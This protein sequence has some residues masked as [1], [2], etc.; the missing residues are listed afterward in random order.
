MRSGK[1]P[2]TRRPSLVFHQLHGTVPVEP[3]GQTRR[4]RRLRPPSRR[5][6]QGTLVDHLLPTRRFSPKAVRRVD[7]MTQTACRPCLP[8]RSHHPSRR[9][10]HWGADGLSG[11]PRWADRRAVGRIR[12]RLRL[13]VVP[14]RVLAGLAPAGRHPARHPLGCRL[15]LKRTLRLRTQTRQTLLYLRLARNRHHRFLGQSRKRLVR[16]RRRRLQGQARQDALGRRGRWRPLLNPDFLVSRQNPL[17]LRRRSNQTRQRRGRFRRDDLLGRRQ[18]LR[19]RRRG[20]R[21]G[22][23]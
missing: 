18:R 12:N 11:E 8:I 2:I 20:Y 9:P 21:L 14:F 19:A 16:S 17:C 4:R 7:P 13:L 1:S 15:Q 6:R 23:N 5:R 10:Y 22:A 3:K